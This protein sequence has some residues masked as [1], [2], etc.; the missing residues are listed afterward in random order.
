MR[1]KVT[2]TYEVWDG[3]GNHHLSTPDYDQ[4]SKLVDELRDRNLYARA[5]TTSTW[6]CHKCGKTV[7]TDRGRDTAC[8]D[9]GAQYSG[10]G[11]R[12]R[13]NW[14]DNRSNY[15][16]SVGDMEGYEQS[17]VRAEVGL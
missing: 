8:Y 3:L 10:Y 17:C 4:A 5:I 9:C 2:T 13:D 15:D 12:L 14:R 11:H 1:E 16:S 6:P 7:T